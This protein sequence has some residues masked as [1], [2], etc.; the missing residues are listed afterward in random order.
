VAQLEVRTNEEWSPD[1]RPGNKL[2]F[3]GVG[4]A[5]RGDDDNA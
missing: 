2:E 3:G 4:N 5:G 1:F